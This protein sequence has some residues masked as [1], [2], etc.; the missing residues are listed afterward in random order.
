MNAHLKTLQESAKELDYLYQ[1][2]T[3]FSTIDI[4]IIN[5]IGKLLTNMSQS[6]KLE[7]KLDE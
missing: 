2:G 3:Y 7:S 5:K 4:D 1:E 6:I